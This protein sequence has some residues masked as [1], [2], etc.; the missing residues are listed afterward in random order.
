MERYCLALDLKNDPV[1]IAEYEAYHREI[2]PEIRKSITDSGIINM[3]I[4]RIMNRL[5]MI[6]EVNGSFSGEK[7]DAADAA[8]PKV[9][10]WE[11]LMWKYQ[12]ALPVA[13]P[14]EKWVKMDKIFSL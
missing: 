2:W 1:L 13:K 5:F 11:T 4:Y 9:Q 12:Q 14:G 3:E 8:N 7:K 10:E 6:M